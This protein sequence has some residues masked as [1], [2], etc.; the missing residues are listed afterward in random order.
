MFV[1]VQIAGK[2]VV[3]VPYSLKYVERY[4]EWMQDPFILEAT[5]SEPQSKA[6]AYSSRE[7]WIESKTMLTFIILDA[8]HPT[9]HSGGVDSM[10]G[11]VN[12][13]VGP[14]HSAEI[15]VMIGNSES[16]RRGLAQEAV[17]LI[18]KYGEHRL[19][20]RRYFCK[21][22]EKNYASLKLFGN[23]LFFSRV[24]FDERFKEHELER[25][26]DPVDTEYSLVEIP[27]DE[28]KATTSSSTLCSQEACIPLK[29]AE[30]A[31]TKGFMQLV[32][33]E[34]TLGDGVVNV[35]VYGHITI[36][37]KCCFISLCGGSQPPMGTLSVAMESQ[38]EPMPLT[39]TLLGDADDD[40]SR[41]ISQHVSKRT[42]TQCF[43]SCSLPDSASLFIPE[44]SEK[45]HDTIIFQ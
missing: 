33:F 41:L 36:L 4:H 15:L 2:L 16:R 39:S 27:Y 7:R 12:L 8:S 19:G 29:V 37:E 24:A 38:F 43:V 9:A 17:E 13:I 23:K 44:I 35:E 42:R 5:A 30:K 40:V 14:D 25:L 26:V 20:L 34:M 11:D 6:E 45:I 18:M 22:S 21:I 31:K 32:T 28:A 10:A 1:T 3:L